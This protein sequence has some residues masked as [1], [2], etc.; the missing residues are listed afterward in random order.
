MTKEELDKQRALLSSL[1]PDEAIN[2]IS[3]LSAAS[4]YSGTTI[5]TS[6]EGVSVTVKRKDDGSWAATTKQAGEDSLALD[7][8]GDTVEAALVAALEAF[9]LFGFSITRRSLLNYIKQRRRELEV[10]VNAAYSHISDS[11]V[12]H[13]TPDAEARRWVGAA[14]MDLKKGLLALEQALKG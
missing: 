8:Q 10:L 4:I 5:I 2:L 7:V 3:L 14:R 9:H 11:N 12:C 1:A 6:C 13:G